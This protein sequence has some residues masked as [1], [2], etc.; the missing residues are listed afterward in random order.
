MAETLGHASSLQTACYNV[1]HLQRKFML[2]VQLYHSKG[3][4]ISR[5]SVFI[6]LGRDPNSA[7]KGQWEYLLGGI[8]TEVFFR[9][10]FLWMLI[11]FVCVAHYYCLHGLHEFLNEGKLSHNLGD[12]SHT[13]GA[14]TKCGVHA[15]SPSIPTWRLAPFSSLGRPGTEATFLHF[16]YY[17]LRDF[18]S[19]YLGQYAYSYGPLSFVDYRVGKLSTATAVALCMRVFWFLDK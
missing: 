8:W 17:H 5:T 4:S 15:Y 16:W 6:Q 10:Y 19:L 13:A 2:A 12:R 18:R 11:N 14:Q 1:T 7:N 9:V 3:Q